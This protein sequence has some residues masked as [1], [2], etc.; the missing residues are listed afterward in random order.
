MSRNPPS[1]RRPAPS[2]PPQNDQGPPSLRWEGQSLPPSEGS[3]PISSET[4]SEDAQAGAPG[5]EPLPEIPVEPL[6]PQADVEAASS[7]A[8]MD[9]EKFWN[10]FSG[11]FVF[12][13]N[14]YAMLPPLHMTLQSLTRA[15][16]LPTARP[17]S[18]AIYELAEGYDWLHWLI[19]EDA[20]M[21]KALIVIGAF[22]AQVAQ[23][24]GAEVRQHR[25][26]I[27]ARMQEPSESELGPQGDLPPHEVQPNV[28]PMVQ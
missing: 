25:A 2:S 15:P 7:V 28:Q 17:A 4:I 14:T 23:G 9:K 19:E 20:S 21:V 16:A 26:L 12:A 13:G 5:Q 22:G 1:R 10:F 24:V 27:A 18:D 6:E 11:L 8:V 3:S